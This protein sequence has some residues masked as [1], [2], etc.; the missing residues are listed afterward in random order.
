MHTHTH[1]TERKRGIGDTKNFSEYIL[2]HC[3]TNFRLPDPAH[4]DYPDPETKTNDSIFKMNQRP[5]PGPGPV[6]LNQVIS[7]VVRDCQRYE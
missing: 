2:R 7:E 1:G 3:K 5:S 6:F 4:L